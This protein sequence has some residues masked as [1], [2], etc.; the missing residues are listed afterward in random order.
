MNLSSN[1]DL[2]SR[3]KVDIPQLSI[4]R[5]RANII[6]SGGLKPYEEDYWKEMRIGTSEYLAVTRTVRCKLPNTDQ[7]TGVK[8]PAEPDKTMKKYRNIDKGSPMNACMGLQLVPKEQEAVV[9]V[10]DKL[11]VLTTG[12]HLYIPL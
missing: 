5:F 1:Q 6:V 10:G 9:S 3:I 11:E 2:N 4:A 12:D 7:D 8:H